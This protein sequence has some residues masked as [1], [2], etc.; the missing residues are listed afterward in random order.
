MK[1]LTLS[2]PMS[3]ISD[4]LESATVAKRRLRRSVRYCIVYSRIL[5]HSVAMKGRQPQQRPVYGKQTRK[6]Y[7]KSEKLTFYHIFVTI[8]NI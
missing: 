8:R 7:K 6:R 1:F 2:L 4:V 3:P 5:R